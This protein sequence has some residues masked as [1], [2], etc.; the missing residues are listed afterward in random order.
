MIRLPGYS[1]FGCD[2]VGKSGGG[3]A[4]YLV[5]HFRAF[6][7][8]CSD[9][10][11]TGRSKFI[12]AEIIFNRSKLLL[13]MFFQ[14]FLEFQIS[15]MHSVILGDFNV[16]MNQNTLIVSRLLHQSSLYQVPFMFTHHLSNSSTLLD[17]CIIDNK[18]KFRKFKEFGQRGVAFLSA[19]D[20]IF[21]K[22]GIKLQRHHGK[23]IVYRD[24]SGFDA[25]SFQSDV[26]DI[27]WTGILPAPWLTD[28]IR[29]MRD[30]D[31]A[32]RTWRR[33]KNDVFYDRYNM[34]RNRAQNLVR[35]AKRE[36]RLLG[37][38]KAR[39]TGGRLSHSVEE[40]NT[41]FGHNAEYADYME[42]GKVPSWDIGRVLSRAK[43]N[44]IGG[45]GISL[46]LMKLTIHCTLPILE[47]LFNFS[48]MNSVSSVNWKSALICPIPKVRNHTLVQHYRLISIL[49]TLSKAT[50]AYTIH[51]SLLR[52]NHSTQTCLI[53]MLDKV[54]HAA[55]RRMVIAFVFF[56]FLKAFDT[57]TQAVKDCIEGTTSSPSPV[58]VGVPQGFVLGPMLFT[59]YLADFRHVVKHCKYNFYADDLQAYIH[60]E[61]RDLSDTIRKVNEDIDAIL[62]W[63]STNRLILNSDK[64][65][66]I[67]MGTSRFVKAID[68]STLPE[69]RMDG[70]MIQ[71][72]T[73]VKYLGVT[74]MNTLSW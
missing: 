22:Y 23:L 36:L 30:R 21:I 1:L 9:G 44:A 68:L 55:D 15:Y 57:R 29:M 58:R 54:R 73:S 43:S 66:A 4:F 71:Y 42:D 53:R 45:D 37:L 26:S 35:S 27:D 5:D 41:F 49:P 20:L 16:D 11:V 2:R 62:G 19:Q 12:M 51:V 64:T 33:H 56:D 61:P 31:L 59:L 47:H 25:A 17:L 3:V 7:L 28:G 34:L 70:S 10:S 40:L 6:I 50:L 69:I 13:A 60:C 67:I 48:L 72:S 24:S 46:R 52:N 63:S 14:S 8:C 74:I 18:D 32:R 38:S 65:Q 39:D